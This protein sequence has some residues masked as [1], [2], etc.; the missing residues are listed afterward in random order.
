MANPTRVPPGPF[1]PIRSELAL[2]G[3]EPPSG[4]ADYELKLGAL[5]LHGTSDSRRENLTDLVHQIGGGT[6]TW[7]SGKVDLLE[8]AQQLVVSMQPY[9][10]WQP[11]ELVLSALLYDDFSIGASATAGLRT[12]V[13]KPAHEIYTH[14]GYQPGAFLSASAIGQMPSTAFSTGPMGTGLLPCYE[15]IQI[16]GSHSTNKNEGDP[17]GGGDDPHGPKDT[18]GHSNSGNSSGPPGNEGGGA[19]QSPDGGDNGGGGGRG[20]PPDGGI[21][22]GLG[23]PPGLLGGNPWGGGLGAQ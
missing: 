11:S 23:G 21:P 9:Q 2:Q 16:R 4:C 10:C 19:P 8:F 13:F 18:R 1:D 17:P 5:V 7:P 12:A 20:G 3:I 14:T 15:Q 6:Y 22:E